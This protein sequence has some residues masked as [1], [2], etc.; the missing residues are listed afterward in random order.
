MSEE[1]ER[2]GLKRNYQCFPNKQTDKK[3]KL[4][5]R[6]ENNWIQTCHSRQGH[7]TKLDYSFPQPGDKVPPLQS[8]APRR[9][10]L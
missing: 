7:K 10:K 3:N 4:Y 8:W 1:K 5:V 9:Q 6:Y 2:F